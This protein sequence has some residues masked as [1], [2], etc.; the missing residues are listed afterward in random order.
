LLHQDNLFNLEANVVLA[1]VLNKYLPAK[2]HSIAFHILPPNELLSNTHTGDEAQNTAHNAG[3]LNTDNISLAT[4]ALSFLEIQFSNHFAICISLLSILISHSHSFLAHSSIATFNSF[5]T[6]A[7]H[8]LMAQAFTSQALVN[9]LNVSSSIVFIS[10]A[11]F[12]VN[13]S[14][15]ISSDTL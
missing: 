14:F 1:L 8:F 4:S 12:H 5:L 13:L 10:S 15:H 2:A 11:S 7:S 6:L 3:L 9:I